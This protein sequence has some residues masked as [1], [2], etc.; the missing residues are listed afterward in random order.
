[1]T[2]EAKPEETPEDKRT[3][4]ALADLKVWGEKHKA[5]IEAFNPQERAADGSIATLAARWRIMLAPEK[6]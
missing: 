5:G 2:D 3:A 4:A 6:E 1:M